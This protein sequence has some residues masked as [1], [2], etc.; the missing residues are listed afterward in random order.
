MLLRDNQVI[1]ESKKRKGTNRGYSR[2]QERVKNWRYSRFHKRVDLRQKNSKAVSTGRRNCSR[3]IAIDYYDELVKRLGGSPASELSYGSNTTCVNDNVNADNF[4]DDPS[5]SSSNSLSNNT[6]SICSILLHFNP[7]RNISNS[8]W[9]FSYVTAFF[10]N[11]V[12]RVEI[13]TQDENLRIILAL[14]HSFTSFIE[15][16]FV[17]H[18]DSI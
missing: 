14:V 18:F 6:P 5:S 3:Q 4:S 16:R 9:I 10:F 15:I 17:K 7:A 13:S 1:S 8:V 12:Y 2:V 11:S